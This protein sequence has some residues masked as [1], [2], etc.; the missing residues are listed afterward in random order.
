MAMMVW[1]GLRWMVKR[2]N[3]KVWLLM[4]EVM[5][6][7]RGC[8]NRIVREHVRRGGEI[9][10]VIEMRGG[11][12]AGGEI[13]MIVEM[14]GGVR[15]G[16]EIVMVIEMRGGVIAGGEIAMIVEMRRGVIAAEKGVEAC[17]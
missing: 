11:V 15:R 5:V 10:M 13:A 7:G 4:L 6:W 1:C 12:M 17:E 16:G 2:R 8:V 9:V 14:R 3:V